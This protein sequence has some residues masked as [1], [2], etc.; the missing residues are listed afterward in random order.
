MSGVD[1]ALALARRV[2]GAEARLTQAF[3]ERLGTDAAAEP[4]LFATGDGGV[5]LHT[6]VE[7]PLNKLVGC[8]LEGAIDEAELARIENAFAA[9]GSGVQCEISTLARVEVFGQLAARGYRLVAVEHVLGCALPLQLPTDPGL[10]VTVA[11][12]GER[13][14]GEWILGMVDAFAAGDGTG[15][16]TADR[17]ARAEIATAMRQFAGVPG[18]E[19]F[20]VRIASSFAGGASMRCDPANIA[21]LCGAGTVPQLRRRGVQSALL[22]HRL[23][24]AATRGC[25][26]AVITTQPGSRSQQNAERSGFRL[27]H[28][29]LVLVRP[30]G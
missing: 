24:V 20:T 18:V 14:L 11:G 2:E 26:V 12:N 23:A 16:G 9:R 30:T 29:R 19:R 15:A 25:D 27:L 10:D 21:Q 3:G 8:G 6:G 22:R 5:A 28:A 7:S 4:L 1:P 13:E 17:F